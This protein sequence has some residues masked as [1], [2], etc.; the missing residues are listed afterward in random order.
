MNVLDAVAKLLNQWD[1]I[2]RLIESINI[3]STHMIYLLV[4]IS[5]IMRD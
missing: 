4:V 1:E 3:E 2:E 5:E